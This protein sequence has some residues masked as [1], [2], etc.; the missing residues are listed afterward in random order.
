MSYLLRGKVDVLNE[1]EVKNDVNNPLRVTIENGPTAPALVEV[2][3]GI[4]INSGNINAY[5][6]SGQLTAYIQSG[7]VN[8]SSGLFQLM[9]SGSPVSTTNP[10]PVILGSGAIGGGMPLPISFTSNQTDA[11][12]RLRVSNPFTLFDSQHRYKT[13]DRWD[14]VSSGGG[15]VSY[16]PNGSLVNL[17]T[18]LASGSRVVSE[19]KRVMAYQPGKSLLIYSTF[20]MCSGQTGQSQKV[21]YF[22]NDNGVYFEMDGTTPTFVL[23]SSVSGTM[24]ETR[25]AR[26]S[27]N[28][29]NLDG[30]GPSGLNITNYCSSMILFIDIEW[31][32]VGDVR[33]GFII[34][35]TFVLCH[36][37]RHTVGSTNPISG[38]YMTTACL[39]LRYEITNTAA[40]TRSGNLKQI[41]NTVVSEGGYQGFSRRFNTSLSTSEK[42]LT[43]ADVGQPVISLRLASGRTDAVVI[44]SN[45]NLILTSNQNIQYR[46]ILNPSLS[47]G[48]NWVT[49]YAGNVQYD[50]SS[51]YYASG[52]GTDI[53]GGY[54]NNLGSLNISDINDFNFQIGRTI[55]GVSDIISLV[56]IPTS[57]NTKLLADVSWYEII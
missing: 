56:A 28:V 29:D 31:L 50:L 21:G 48:T 43:T 41:C 52:T 20:T 6:A 32:G 46:L 44:P 26:L 22:G 19:T 36:I 33:V 14:Y 9:S 11:F 38:T 15:S 12:G 37:F 49:H 23:R 1:V 25:K 34:N 35:G 13:N 42:T 2:V 24:A 47:S 16:D 8:V 53:L 18:N 57:S 30:N 4:T 54:V 5:I 39:P 40:V 7:N 45:I 10:L 27:W 55:D 51:T 17:N 3:N